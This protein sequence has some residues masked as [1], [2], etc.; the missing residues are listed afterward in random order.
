MLQD[1]HGQAVA[2][3]VTY[4]LSSG[5]TNTMSGPHTLDDGF[6]VLRQVAPG[7]YRFGLKADG[8]AATTVELIVPREGHP[9][10]APVVITMRSLQ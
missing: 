5:S 6:L 1:Q 7:E 9:E 10:D 8:L 2:S 3:P 4:T